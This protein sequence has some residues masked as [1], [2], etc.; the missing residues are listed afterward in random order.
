MCQ[1]N[2]PRVALCCTKES[3]Q[4]HGDF[5]RMPWA[6]R[7]SAIADRSPRWCHCRGLPCW[8]WLLSMLHIC[9]YMSVKLCFICRPSSTLTLTTAVTSHQTRWRRLWRRWVVHQAQMLQRWSGSMTSTMMGRSITM[10]LF[11][12]WGSR[13]TP[14]SRPAHFSKGSECQRLCSYA[15]EHHPDSTLQL[16]FCALFMLSIAH[17]NC[18]F[19]FSLNTQAGWGICRWG[20]GM[21]VVEMCQMA[22]S[23]CLAVVLLHE[24]LLSTSKLVWAI[25]CAMCMFDY[26]ALVIYCILVTCNTS[27]TQCFGQQLSN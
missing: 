24:K 7:I 3:Q 13:T 5:S 12:C 21:T 15:L 14:C 16:F 11:K 6:C 8:I 26:H 27:V 20:R 10:S 19:L 17:K 4:M 18:M 1:G 2:T 23:C 22:W 9:A 25:I